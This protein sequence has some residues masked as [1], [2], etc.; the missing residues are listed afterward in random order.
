VSL[1]HILLGIL[2]AAIWGTNFVAIKLG[3][4]VFQ[5]FTLVL[6][7]FF[8]TTIPLIF[9]LPLPKTPWRQV[10]GLALFMWVGQF[11]PMFTA[12]HLG[13]SPGLSSLLMQT[14][15]ILT[16]I[17]S[18]II[19][20]SRLN[21]LN[22]T[23]L[24]ISGVGLLWIALQTGQQ[25]ML[26][27]Y[28]LVFTSAFSVSI[29]NILIK[30]TEDE[31]LFSL[32]CWSNLLA[33][34]PMFGITVYIEGG[35][36]QIWAQLAS[37]TFLSGGSI[38]YTSYISSMIGFYLWAYLMRYYPPSAV[39]PFTLLVPV[40]GMSSCALMLD[41]QFTFY[42][43]LASGVVVFGLVINYIGRLRKR[44]DMLQPVS[45]PILQEAA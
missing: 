5:P 39:A 23:G 10:V 7:R 12:I 1:A 15:V 17:W 42:N 26:I 44:P 27:G 28:L 16:T 20:K 21:K 29:G 22:I 36:D 11:L 6:I 37:I 18:V 35:V 30:T 2:I 45:E 25:G 14:Q 32:L 43:I 19:F 41:E 34:I 4:E 8:L 13:M 31:N 3:C 9:F 40:F 38:L 24:A 33:L